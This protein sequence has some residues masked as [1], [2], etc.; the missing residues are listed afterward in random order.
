MGWHVWVC[1]Q[2]LNKKLKGYSYYASRHAIQVHDSSGRIL[3][4]VFE[5]MFWITCQVYPHTDRIECLSDNL[6]V[7]VCVC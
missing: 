3:S 7:N 4:T 2:I 6:L 5:K 1:F